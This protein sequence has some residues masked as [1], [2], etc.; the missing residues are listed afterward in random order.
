M[1]HDPLHVSVMIQGAHQDSIMWR[2]LTH[3]RE[4][5]STVSKDEVVAVFFVI[6]NWGD[7]MCE[8]K[9]DPVTCSK[10]ITAGGYCHGHSNHRDR[11]AGVRYL[12]EFREK[13]KI[14]RDSPHEAVFCVNS[15]IVEGMMVFPVH[16]IVELRDA[17]HFQVK[18]ISP[19]Q[20][21]GWAKRMIFWIKSFVTVEKVMLGVAVAAAVAMRLG[22]F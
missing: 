12:Q 10:Y 20:L 2:F 18:L 9:P 22:R 21:L 13:M 3:I 1:E 4:H 5:N 17:M 7:E 14:P 15:A 19:D 6:T 16:G 8:V 11:E